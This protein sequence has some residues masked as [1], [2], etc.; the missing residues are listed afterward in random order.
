RFV[1]V[2][3]YT[4][5]GCTHCNHEAPST[6]FM[7]EEFGRARVYQQGRD[8]AEA[9]SCRQECFPPKILVRFGS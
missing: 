8:T 3:E 2:D 4:C 6:F 7:E 5:I 1:Y 9:V